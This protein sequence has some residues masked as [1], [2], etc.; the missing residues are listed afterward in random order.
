MRAQDKLDLYSHIILNE[1]AYFYKK[2]LAQ[3]DKRAI[4][5]VFGNVLEGIKYNL[6]TVVK[7]REEFLGLEHTKKAYC[8]LLVYKASSPSANFDIDKDDFPQDLME[9]KI[10]Y[11]LIVEINDYVIIVKKNIS[12]LTYFLNQLQP[13]PGTILGDILI[14][15]DTSFQ[16]MKLTG[17]NMNEEAMR[18]RSYEANDLENSMPMYSANQNIVTSTRFTSGEQVC[19]L[20]ISTSRLAKFGAKKNISPLLVWINMVVDKLENYVPTNN[21]LG[22]F[23]TPVSWKNV[24]DN[25]VP[26]SLLINIYE[27]ENFIQSLDDP[28][29]YRRYKQGEDPQCRTDLF[30]KI[31]KN[32]VRCCGLSHKKEDFYQCKGYSPMTGIKIQKS[33]IKVVASKA[34]SSLCYK[35]GDKYIS[36]VDLINERSY[37]SVGFE[38]YSYIYNSR[39][40][41]RNGKIESDLDSILSIFEPCEELSIVRSEKGEGYNEQS[42]NFS[43]DSM[44]HIVETVLFPNADYIVCDDMGNEWADHIVIQSH[45]ISFAHSKCKGTRSL[46]ASNFHDVIGQASKNIGHLMLT[47]QEMKSKK[48]SWEG[49]WGNTSINRCRRGS[50]D[51]IMTAIKSLRGNPNLTKEVCLC[52][53]FISKTQLTEAF[54]KLKNGESHRQKNSVVQM[55]W[56]LNGFISTCKELDLHCRIFCVP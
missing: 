41:Y 22:R 1:G 14:D 32:G 15:A 40:I 31:A 53:D 36:L 20:N 26:C 50:I 12:H 33:G 27:V 25:I 10:S 52:I 54:S 6:L 4:D 55:V 18:N 51:D 45:T 37:F 19:T 39:N 9:S 5:S 8:S 30:S 13:I 48:N 56:L 16:Q 2:G 29:I 44:F 43:T 11:L 3:I 34:L 24:R 23:A 17:M 42:Q 38:D 35:Q 28:N 49:C 46:S 47:D 21:F 7:K